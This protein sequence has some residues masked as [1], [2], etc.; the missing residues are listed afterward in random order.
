M[1]WRMYGMTWRS[2]VCKRQ[3]LMRDAG[4]GGG[5]PG[6]GEMMARIGCV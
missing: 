4:I 3:H 5:I 1:A 2:H 6:G